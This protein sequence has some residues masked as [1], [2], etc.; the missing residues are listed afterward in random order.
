MIQHATN[1]SWANGITLCSKWGTSRQ[2]NIY[3]HDGSSN[4]QTLS[5]YTWTLNQWYHIAAERHNGQ[6]TLYVN[7]VAEVTR[8]DTRTYNVASSSEGVSIGAQSE[9]SYQSNGYIQDVR[10]YKGVAKY[11]GG[12]DVNKP[13][14]PVN[15]ASWRA[16]PDN[17]KNNFATFNPLIG[18]G[19]AS[20][21]T[22]PAL[23]DGNLYL[24]NANQTWTTST[25]GVS[26]GKYYAEFM[27]SGGSM[28]SNIGVCGDGRHGR[29]N[30]QYH[31]ARTISYIR[32]HST[33]V[34]KIGRAHV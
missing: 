15:F 18:A 33:A 26:S 25:I 32:L 17:C 4:V 9:G 21:D 6:L 24:D 16:V 12:F 30:Q 27:L 23:N 3:T 20:G 28:G 31:A 5:P 1:G 14:R 10:V 8:A 11:K 19:I 13:Y 2:F 7:G 22:V 34:K 29:N